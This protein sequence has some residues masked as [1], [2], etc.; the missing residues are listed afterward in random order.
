VFRGL[1]IADDIIHIHADIIGAV[2][3]LTTNPSAGNVIGNGN[4]TVKFS[5]EAIMKS[6]E[7]ATTHNYGFG[8]KRINVRYW[9]E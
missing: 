7:F 9:F 3:S 5:S 6:T 1:I 4:G 8:A 2:V